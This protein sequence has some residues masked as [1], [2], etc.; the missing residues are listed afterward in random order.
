MTAPPPAELRRDFL[1]DPDVAFL[2]HGSFG[3]CP[4]PVFDSYQAHQRDLEWEPIDFLDRRLPIL[5]ASARDE[6]ARYLNAPGAD[7]AF[8]V[9]ATTGVNLAARSLDLGP[10]DEVLTTDL[11]Y[12]ACDLAWQWLADRAGFAYVRAPIPLPLASPTALFEALFAHATERTRV[13]YVSHIT[14]ATA[15][16]LPVEDIVARAH[17]L[18]LVT[19]VDGAHAPAHVPLDVE[20]L[21]ADFY[22][23]NTH[24]WLMSPKGAAFLHVRPEHQERVDAAMVSWGYAEGRGFQERVEMQGTRDPAAWLA[25]PDAIRYQAERE[26]D[27]VRERCRALTRE[28]RAKLCELFGTEPLAPEEML[29]QMA[30]VRLPR[31]DPGLRDRLFANHRV[32][33]PVTGPNDDL[34]RISIAAYTTRDEIDRLSAALARELHA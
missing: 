15:L 28:A 19:I 8:V 34:L 27:A 1:L 31:P 5:L 17:E 23:G 12:G 20:A 13:V 16:I 21:G 25:V 4:R 14:S 2:N 32:E 24:K 11:E 7:L 18:G 9:N 10:G 29:G 3:A 26:W 30:S 6:L 22:T 33:I